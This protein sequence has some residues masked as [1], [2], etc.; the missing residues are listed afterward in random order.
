MAVVLDGQQVRDQSIE[1]VDLASGVTDKLLPDPTNVTDGWVLTKDE[2]SPGKRKY[3]A[4]GAASS[5]LLKIPLVLNE[6]TNSATEVV[7][8]A[9]GF[10]RTKYSFSSIKLRAIGSVTAANYTGTLKLYEDGS[11]VATLTFTSTTPTLT[12]SSALTLS[13][14]E[15]NLEARIYMSSTL[16]SVIVAAAW[17]EITP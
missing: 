4:P 9:L 3:A 13:A 12:T 14:A 7:V 11:L 17:L 16:A 6:T 2:A 5:P 10:D 15:K 8:G 1:E